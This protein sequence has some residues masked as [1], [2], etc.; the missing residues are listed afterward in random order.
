VEVEVFH[1]D[2]WARPGAEVLAASLAG[3]REHVA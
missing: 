1:A 2:V 3:Y